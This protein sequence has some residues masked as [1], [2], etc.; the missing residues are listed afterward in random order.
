MFPTE[1]ELPAWESKGVEKWRVSMPEAEF[2]GEGTKAP[3]EASIV[4]VSWRVLGLSREGEEPWRAK[5][6][7]SKGFSAASLSGTAVGGALKWPVRL[8]ICSFHCQAL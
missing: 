7:G 8:S 3:W 6:S 4:A 1:T 2:R 5:V